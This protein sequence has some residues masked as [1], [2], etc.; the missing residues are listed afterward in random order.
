MKTNFLTIGLLI[1]GLSSTLLKA[2]LY[3]A[4]FP[5]AVISNNYITMRLLLPDPDQ[6]SY[7]ATRFDWSGIISSLKY[8][9]HEYFG[10][11]KSTHDPYIHE[12]LSGPAESYQDPGLGYEEAKPGDGFIRI[13]VGILEKPDEV[14]YR[15]SDTYKIIDHGKWKTKV[16]KDRVR[17]RHSLQSD[18][19]YGYIYTKTIVLN[20]KK[21]GFSIIHSLKNTGAKSIETDQY[22][23]NF[24]MIDQAKSGP[25]LEFT[26]PF[27][28]K[29]SDDLKG[30]MK[31]EKN[32]L[33]FIKP[34]R[35]NHVWMEFTGFGSTP[36]DHQVMVMNKKTGAGIQLKVDQ[37]LHRMVFW[38][39]ET[40]YCPENFI[41]L[42]VLPGEEIKW[43]SDY[44]LILE[45]E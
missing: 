30:Y 23:H 43:I 29:T 16:R 2:Q 34:L 25:D 10:Y 8:Q 13:G 24:F 4:D 36:E 44:T 32:K 28:A 39:C 31:L 26:F 38:A 12:D 37:P 7:R 42:S 45:K 5:N 11:W 1:F 35:N 33:S 14:E 15:W 22:N 6:G 41:M 18:F 9:G 27:E 20:D 21:P 40:T 19:G 17:F 3:D